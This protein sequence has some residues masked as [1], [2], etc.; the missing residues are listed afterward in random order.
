MEVSEI[1]SMDPSSECK[2]IFNFSEEWKHCYYQKKNESSSELDPDNLPL[3]DEEYH[4]DTGE[5]FCNSKGQEVFDP[6]QE[7]EY[8]LYYEVSATSTYSSKT[9]TGLLQ[10]KINDLIESGDLSTESEEY[11][12]MEALGLYANPEAIMELFDSIECEDYKCLKE[13]SDYDS[14]LWCTSSQLDE[15]NISFSFE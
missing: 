5:P 14:L 8:E 15:E 13:K 10:K 9:F 3:L 11:E 2:I 12:V 1:L 4:G 6:T 7:I